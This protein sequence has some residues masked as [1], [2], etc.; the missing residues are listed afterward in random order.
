MAIWRWHIPHPTYAYESLCACTHTSLV[1]DLSGTLPPNSCSGTWRSALSSSASPCMV[2]LL[3]CM[4][5]IMHASCTCVH[6]LA[7]HAIADCTSLDVS[8]HAYTRHVGESVASPF[9]TPYGA[10]PV[11]SWSCTSSSILGCFTYH[12]LCFLTSM[13]GKSLHVCACCPIRAH[14]MPSMQPVKGPCIA[15]QAAFV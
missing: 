8:Y 4:C 5:S 3:L 10:Q 15:A 1:N 14:P 2:G 9:A 11:Q 12:T 6:V 13:H 7:R